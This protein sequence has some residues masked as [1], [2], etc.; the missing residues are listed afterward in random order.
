MI[1]ETKAGKASSTFGHTVDSWQ[2]GTS[3]PVIIIFNMTVTFTIHT[4]HHHHP[5]TWRVQ[6]EGE[7]SRWC[8][9]GADSEWQT[10]VLSGH[11][12]P[13]SWPS[14]RKAPVTF[15]CLQLVES[16]LFQ[17]SVS[18]ALSLTVQQNLQY[19]RITRYLIYITKN[20]IFW[21]H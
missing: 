19:H 4:C 7:D 13:D 15:G 5:L 11:N 8:L 14:G 12:Y 10:L 9:T 17:R 16:S 1:A 20:K 21:L 18:L 3:V 6:L 2:T